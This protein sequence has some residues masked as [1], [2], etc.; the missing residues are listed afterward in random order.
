MPELYTIFD[1]LQEVNH[2]KD[3]MLSRVCVV[4][5]CSALLISGFYGRKP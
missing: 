4:H 1:P 5:Q 3:R 2:G